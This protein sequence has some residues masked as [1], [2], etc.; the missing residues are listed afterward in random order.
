MIGVPAPFPPFRTRA[1]WFGGDLQTIRNHVLHDYADLTNWPAEV[2]FFPMSNGDRLS[3]SLH[4]PEQDRK[5]P[6]IIL[7]HGFTGCADSACLLGSA[8]HLLKSGFPVMR[9]NLRGA[10]PTRPVCREM[11]H[12]GRSDDFRRVL[13]DIPNRLTQNGLVAVGFSLGES[14]L[15]KYLGEEGTATPL[16]AAVTISAPIDLGLATRRINAV[17]NIVYHRWLVANTKREWL[18]GPSLLDGQQLD[19]VHRSKTIYALDDS[20]VGPINGFSGADDYYTRHS[21]AQFLGDI[22]VPTLL[23]HAA[24]DPWIPASMYQRVEWAEND[25]LL[26]AITP[27]GGHVGFHGRDGRWHDRSVVRFLDGVSFKSKSFEAAE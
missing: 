5:L 4:W 3:A 18:A 24:N 27:S 25:N 11:Y 14:M 15:L 19:A 2:F 9:L 8:Q 20:V 17:R 26:P 1:P 16:D 10:G 6:T 21:A 12:A 13:A 23:I 7:I 22:N